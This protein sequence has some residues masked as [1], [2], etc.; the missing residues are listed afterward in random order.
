[1][2]RSHSALIGGQ[3]STFTQSRKEKITHQVQPGPLK[4][5]AVTRPGQRE[6]VTS[7]SPVKV[8]EKQ[9]HVKGDNSGLVV[10]SAR[11]VSTSS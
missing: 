10:T 4:A 9:A 7:S 8:L 2:Q 6:R 1:M 11:I 5:W 3:R